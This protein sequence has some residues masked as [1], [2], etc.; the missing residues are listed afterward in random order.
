MYTRTSFRNKT[1]K[2]S[3]REGLMNKSTYLPTYYLLFALILLNNIAYLVSTLWSSPYLQAVGGTRAN[4]VIAR[5]LLRLCCSTSATMQPTQRRSA[6]QCRP[7]DKSQQDFA[8]QWMKALSPN[9]CTTSSPSQAFHSTKAIASVLDSTFPNFY[10][11]LNNNNIGILFIVSG[12]ELSLK[13]FLSHRELPS[14]SMAR[15]LVEQR[16]EQH[17]L[18]LELLSR[19]RQ[20]LDFD[21]NHYWDLSR[22]LTLTKRLHTLFQSIQS[23]PR[24]RKS[25]N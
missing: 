3:R 4:V 25:T 24:F 6:I 12:T 21:A 8:N 5:S 17:R 19:Y 18:Q 2:P 16:S 14:A 22:S 11:F 10:F 23:H 9:I 1:N 13:E 20:Q 7:S 15:D